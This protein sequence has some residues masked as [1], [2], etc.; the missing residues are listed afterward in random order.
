MGY[1]LCG[2]ADAI[3]E[4]VGVRFGKHKYRVPSLR[5]VEV[6]ER[7]LEGSFSVFLVSLILSTFFFVCLYRMPL[8]KSLIASIV[9]S[10]VLALVE[11]VSFHGSDNL[12]IQVTASGLAYFFMR[13]WA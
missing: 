6:A 9:L 13:V 8:G 5:K 11:A 4:P 10:L 3:A 7:S 12:T 1:V 2:A